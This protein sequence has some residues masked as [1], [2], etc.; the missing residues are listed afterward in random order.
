MRNLDRDEKSHADIIGHATKTAIFSNSRRRTAAI[1]K[2][3]VSPYLSR[4]LSDFDQIWYADANFHS[5]DGHLTTKSKFCKLKMAVG[6]HIE[7]CFSDISRCRILA[8]LRE[9]WRRD[10]ESH[11]HIG[12]VTKTAIFD[13]TRWR[14]GGGV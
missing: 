5:E 14:T 8:D 6:R 11:E 2:I 13:N 3:A 10:A 9:I 1:L 12:H 4:E 7:N